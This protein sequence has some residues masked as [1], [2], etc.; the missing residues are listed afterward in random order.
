MKRIGYLYNQITDFDNLRQAEANAR[1]GKKHQPGVKLFDQNPEGNLLLLN[2]VLI[3]KDFRTSEYV[4]FP[5]YEPKERLIFKLPYYPDRIVH[6]AILNVLKSYFTLWFTADTYA[7]IEGRGIHSAANAI[8]SALKNKSATQYCLKLD[9]KKFYPN[10][11]HQILKALIRRKIKDQDLLCLLDNIIDSAEGLPIGNYLSQYFANFYLTNFDH[12]LKE[13]QK[14]KYYFRYADDLVLLASNKPELHAYLQD[15]RIYLRDNLKLEVKHNYQVFKVE[16]RGI[17][18]VGYVFY[19][20]H[21]LLRKTIKK[22]FA[23]AASKKNP[24]SATIASYLGWA[25]HANTNHLIKKLLPKRCMNT[26]L[27]ITEPSRISVVSQ[28][29]N[30]K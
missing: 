12:W 27:K 11:D 2:D 26:N 21:T 17:D 18:F 4:T 1:K 29:T 30:C 10:I 6:H 13:Q 15:I 3:N 28:E 25:K 8:K 19:H 16:D 7:N 14:V 24:N 5:V 22:R 23:K 9:I 20:T